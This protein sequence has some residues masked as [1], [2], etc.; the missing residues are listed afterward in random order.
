MTVRSKVPCPGCGGRNLFESKPVSAGGGHAPDHL[1]GLGT[2][3]VASQF[4][5]VL[6]QDC[7]LMRSFAVP[8]GI[9]KLSQSKKWKR[10]A[11]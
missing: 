9:A 3:W 1:P 5:V 2:F 8:Q 4:T 7:G 6:C 11:T 10:V